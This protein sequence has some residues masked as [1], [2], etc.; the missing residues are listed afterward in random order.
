LYYLGTGIVRCQEVVVH[1]YGHMDDGY[2]YG[3]GEAY[4]NL[5][6]KQFKSGKNDLRSLEQLALQAQALQKYPEAIEFWHE[7]K[8]IDPEHGGADFNIGHCYAEQGKW[9][10]ALEWTRKALQKS[11]DSRDVLQNLATC[12]AMTGNVEAAEKI[13]HDLIA[14]YPKYPLPQGLLNAI[15]NIKQQG[16]MKHDDVA[17]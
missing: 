9:V 17:L 13:C 12:E 14:R 5:L 1:H 7:V 2:V 10:D 11:P 15:Q 4:Y 16:G 6:H 8:R 3:H